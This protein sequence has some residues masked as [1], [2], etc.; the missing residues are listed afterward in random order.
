MMNEQDIVVQGQRDSV[1]WCVR[2]I[3]IGGLIF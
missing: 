1:W 2:N 3:A